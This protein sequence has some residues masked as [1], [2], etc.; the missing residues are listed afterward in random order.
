MILDA[1]SL[2][3]PFRVPS[4]VQNHVEDLNLLRYFVF[5]V[6]IYTAHTHI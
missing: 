6:C 5:L 3:I 1:Q 4:D 2:F